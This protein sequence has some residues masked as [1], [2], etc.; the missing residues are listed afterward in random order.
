[1]SRLVWGARGQ[2]TYEAGVDRGVFYPQTGQAAPWD[3]LISVST[4]PETLESSE[5]Y[6]DGQKY[7][8]QELVDSFAGTIEAFSYPVELDEPFGFSY[9]TGKSDERGRQ[10]YKIHLVYNVVAAPASAIFGTLDDDPD[11]VNFRWEFYTKPEPVEYGRPTAHLVVDTALAYPEAL[12]QFEEMIYGSNFVEAHLP[13]VAE[14]LA[15]FESHSILKITDHGDGTWT[16]EG[17]DDVVYMVGPDL[18]E[19]D[20]P[21]AV[22][23]DNESYRVSSL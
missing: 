3:G 16:A 2:R 22:Y 12:A 10:S 15:L 8:N 6:Y 17:P 21:S 18:F 11:L 14:V 23:I 13:T 1:M 19:I 5:R 20:W 4:T 9:R 7:H